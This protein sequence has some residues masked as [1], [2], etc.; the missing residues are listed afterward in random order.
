MSSYHLPIV[1]GQNQSERIVVIH[2]VDGQ[3]NYEENRVVIV[4]PAGRN[5]PL[6]RISDQAQLI[7]IG[8]ELVK[9]QFDNG[10]N[11]IEVFVGS[12]SITPRRAHGFWNYRVNTG[13]FDDDV[14][15]SITMK[16]A[17]GN[18]NTLEGRLHIVRPTAGEMVMN[19]NADLGSDATQINYFIPGTGVV[20]SQKVDLIQCFKNGYKTDRDYDSLV[21]PESRE[22][23]F[24]QQEKGT[25]NFY[26]TGNITFKI[27]GDIDASLS[28]SSTFIN[29]I[30][31]S[32]AGK[33]EAGNAGKGTK[34]WDM[35]SAF[36]RKLINIKMLYAHSD[37]PEVTDPV[38]DINFI[39]GIRN[40]DVSNPQ[41]LLQVLQAIYKQLITISTLGINR[42][43]RL[44]SVLLLVPNI[45]IQE[46]IDLLLYEMSKMNQN[47]EGRRF[48]FRIISE[49]DS[50]FVG[51]K[52]ARTAGGNQNILSGILNN[53]TDPRQKDTFLIIDA[54][55]GTT[56]FS[57]VRHDSNA[58]NSNLISLK[59][60][61]IVGAGGAI[62]YVFARVFA[63]QVYNHKG[64]INPGT[65]STVSKSE[66][67]YRFMTLIE[68]LSPV[69]QD[70]MMLI[71]ETLK[72]KYKKEG[73]KIST[74]QVYTC[75]MGVSARTI[76]AA[77]LSDSKPNYKRLVETPEA[78]NEISQ[79]VW[80][81]QTIGLNQD[82]MDEVEWV[83][84]SIAQTVTNEMIFVN[85][86]DSL[87]RQIDYVI[88]NG[89]SFL[90]EPLKK[91]FVDA[92]GPH[93]GIWF[94]NHGVSVYAKRLRPRESYYNLKI[95]P[96]SG[97]NMK[98]VSVEFEQHDLGVNCN[99]DL[100]CT[101]RIQFEGGILDQDQFWHGFDIATAGGK[102]PTRYYI[103]YV[104]NGL[105]YSFA[106]EL[107]QGVTV[108]TISDTRK[109]LVWMTLF[110]V[111]YVP[112]FAD[113]ANQAGTTPTTPTPTGPMPTTPT[114]SGSTAGPTIPIPKS[115]INGTDNNSLS[116]PS[117]NQSGKPVAND[118]H[119]DI[120][121]L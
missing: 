82:D 106:P 51:I 45:Y 76:V 97:F 17:N 2:L 71:V 107:R 66:F 87:N 21:R 3:E 54:G 10:S 86:D 70:R 40:G 50:A 39:N 6:F 99:S 8:G 15:F 9:P 104:N 101:E 110:P 91:A 44:F 96:L 89:R 102:E 34:T 52:E 26:K 5:I 74:A 58:V 108:N 42:Q 119:L 59:R 24:I 11:L 29:Y 113:P 118:D 7:G 19:I 31:V 49:S 64:E 80:G 63:R 69:D 68:K 61:G 94:E 115:G 32:A 100:C 72:K 117:G 73:D 4:P 60:G 78:W 88:F 25:R 14:V 18:G 120:N 27:G 22:P 67:I 53:V 92:I 43:C 84:Q 16:D 13:T 20:G 81:N 55:K 103:G 47:N 12:N 36:N 105:A 30:N 95:A 83:C 23:L 48:D 33:N 93:R 75:F 56:D 62:D 116:I 1:L 28:N 114:P 79:W 57:I 121:D 65:A 38:F 37:I 77:L 109:K 35:E 85:K 98:S 90:F 41:D 46:N 111:S 112:V